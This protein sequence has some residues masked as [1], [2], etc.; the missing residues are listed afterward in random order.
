MIAALALLASAVAGPAQTGVLY[1]GARPVMDDRAP[2]WVGVGG[3]GG[4]VFA[5]ETDGGL[6][7]GALDAGVVLRTPGPDVTLFGHAHGWR[8]AEAEGALA[9]VA[10]GVS[11]V[12]RPGVR[13]TGLLGGGYGHRGRLHG[14]PGLAVLIGPDDGIQLEATAMP[15]GVRRPMTRIRRWTLREDV[16][17]APLGSSE[18]SHGTTPLLGSVGV[19]FAL[20]DRVPE[21]RA[22]MR[23]GYPDLYTLHINGHKRFIDIGMTV[24]GGILWYARVGMWLGRPRNPVKRY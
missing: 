15:W 6:Y 12:D 17:G 22:R 4:V 2:A 16:R 7:G 21:L 8:L 9:A 23:L 3:M 13:V 10:L 18:W 24:P 20:P 14:F 11:L 5:N 1:P 19:S